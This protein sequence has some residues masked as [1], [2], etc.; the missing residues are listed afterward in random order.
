MQW[1]Y[2][3]LADTVLLVHVL[4]VL[5]NVG[6]VPIIWLGYFRKWD[7]VRHSCFRVAHLLLLGFV[8]AETALG[9]T[10][11][12]TTL[13]NWLR[14]RAGGGALYEGSFVTHWLQRLIFWDFDPGVFLLIYVL[15]FGFVLF[16]FYYLRPGPAAWDRKPP[17]VPAVTASG[18]QIS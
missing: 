9:L 16:T 8:T 5:F 13:E 10:C 18:Q 12:L 15:F 3:L 7:I 14:L 4:V 2:S 11:P 1:F 6:A 17:A